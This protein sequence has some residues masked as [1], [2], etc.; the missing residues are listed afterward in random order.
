MRRILIALAIAALGAALPLGS[1]QALPENNA[2]PQQAPPPAANNG[3]P[4]PTQFQAIMV[5]V[6]TQQRIV[7]GLTQPLA[8]IPNDLGQTRA[9]QMRWASASRTWIA[10][11][12]G[13]LAQGRTQ[14][15][16]LGPPP[17]A[18]RLTVIYTSQ[19]NRLGPIIDGFQQYLARYRA[20]VD[21]VERGDADAS[22]AALA[23]IV[24]ARIMVAQQFR[25]LNA[26]GAD[27][28][29]DGNP[30]RPLLRSFAASYDG[31]IATLRVFRQAYYSAAPDSRLQAAD[32]I[33]AATREMHTRTQEGRRFL[34]V[35]LA[36]VAAA[37]AS[38]PA[39]QAFVERYGR[40][41]RTFPASFDR[42]DQMAAELANVE[43]L[44][45]SSQTFQQIWPALNDHLNR[46]GTMDSDRMGDIQRRTA[47][48]QG[49][50]GTQ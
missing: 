20:C 38:T 21:A 2:Q 42:E 16:Q 9:D 6:Q 49:N 24:D 17:P 40:A 34:N 14:I 47:I 18:G 13:V 15:E 44:L 45:R 26:S 46:M 35:Q 41:L 5:W 25:D 23:S 33:Q 28:I 29:E 50:D 39:E 36:A 31:F 11:Y 3:E 4:T 22:L 10:N 27:Q 32:M 30:Q 19:Y 7:V 12:E 43:A 8:S 1:S 48:I 37:H